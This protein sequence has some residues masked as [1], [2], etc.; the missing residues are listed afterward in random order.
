MALT[1]QKRQKLHFPY[2]F[3]KIADKLTAN[4]EILISVAS[5]VDTTADIYQS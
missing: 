2:E 5:L 4:S 3:S 1:F